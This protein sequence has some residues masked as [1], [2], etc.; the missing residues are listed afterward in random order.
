MAARHPYEELTSD[1]LVNFSLT[2]T[3]A[4][5]CWARQAAYSAIDC[6]VIPPHQY[7]ECDHSLSGTR[8]YLGP[9]LPI[10]R[11]EYGA[12]HHPMSCPLVRRL[13]PAILY[14]S[15]DR[16]SPRKSIFF[17]TMPTLG[18][19]QLSWPPLCAKMIVDWE[20][21]WTGPAWRTFTAF[22]AQSLVLHLPACL[23]ES[24]IGAAILSSSVSREAYVTTKIADDIAK[25]LTTSRYERLYIV[26][27]ERPNSRRAHCRLSST[28]LP[29]M[30]Q[31]SCIE[32]KRLLYERYNEQAA[33][34]GWAEKLKVC[35]VAE[36]RT[37]TVWYEGD[38]EILT[39]GQAGRVQK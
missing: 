17:N 19:L 20:D 23:S 14:L 27:H 7:G 16:A 32:I 24:T 1:A 33:E 15:G 18:F 5:V 8:R 4:G 35:S 29:P 39:R 9:G 22:G 25:I 21:G 3:L 13:D 2:P 11:I 30:T 37:L 10:P 34:G 28:K 31:Q 38:E 36:Y 12:M 6:L 26:Y